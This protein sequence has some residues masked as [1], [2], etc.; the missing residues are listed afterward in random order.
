MFSRLEVPDHPHGAGDSGGVQSEALAA[1]LY[2]HVTGRRGDGGRPC[3]R[4]TR[5]IDNPTRTESHW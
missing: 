4:D 2:H 3:Q 5:N 1:R